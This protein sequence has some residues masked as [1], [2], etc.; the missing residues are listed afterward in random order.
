MVSKNILQLSRFSVA[1]AG[2][3][4]VGISTGAVV[5]VST[6]SDRHAFRLDIYMAFR[7]PNHAFNLIGE[8]LQYVVKWGLVIAGYSTLSGRKESKR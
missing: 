6:F 2:L 5:S 7:S 4:A 8:D 3:Q 1:G